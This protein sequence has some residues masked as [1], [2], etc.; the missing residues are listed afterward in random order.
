MDVADSGPTNEE[1][2]TNLESAGFRLSSWDVTYKQNGDAPLRK[3]RTELHWFGSIEAQ[4]TPTVIQKF[5]E[6]QGVKKLRW[7]E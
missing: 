1:V 4:E 5:V 2:H 3:I 6:R 7:R